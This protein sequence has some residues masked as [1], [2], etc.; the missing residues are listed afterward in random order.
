MTTINS[1]YNRLKKIGVEVTMIGNYPW[2]YLD[3]VN[4]KKVKG[5]FQGNKG[6]TIFFTAIKDSQQP[7]TITDIGIIFNKIRETLKL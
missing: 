4:G 6:F 5:T 1:F 3:T 2:I 7:H